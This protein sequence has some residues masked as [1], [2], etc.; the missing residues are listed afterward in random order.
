MATVQM[1]SVWKRDGKIS[2]PSRHNQ[3]Q[4]TM[5]NFQYKHNH[6]SQEETRKTRRKL[7]RHKKKSLP[8]VFVWKIKNFTGIHVKKCFCNIY[9]IISFCTA[10]GFQIGFKLYYSK[11]AKDHFFMFNYFDYIRILNNQ[12]CC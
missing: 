3:V 7:Y 4:S 6:M 1:I 12:I 10:N 5:R 9:Y 11:F 2:R 8:N